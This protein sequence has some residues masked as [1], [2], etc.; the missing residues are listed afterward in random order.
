V[1]VVEGVEP[2]FERVLLAVNIRAM[3]HGEEK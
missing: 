3:H 2:G 1:V